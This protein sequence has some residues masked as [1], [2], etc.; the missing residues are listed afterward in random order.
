MSDNANLFAA[1]E[2][3]WSGADRERVCLET[4][5]GA[6]LTFAALSVMAA[7]YANVLVARGL[8]RGDR[9]SVIAEKSPALIALYLACLRAG[10]AY[11]PLNPTYTPREL[12]FFFEDADSALIV[13]DPAFEATVAEA[14]PRRARLTLD[15]HGGGSLGDAAAHAAPAFETVVSGPRDLAALLYS[16]GTTGTPKGIP[17]TH[18]NL[19]ANAAALA[20][21]WGFS[22]SDVL[23]H[24]LPVYH[25]HGLFITLGPALLSGT[26]LLW[27]ARFEAGAV[28]EALPRATMMAGVPTY[29]TRLL[30]E[31]GLDRERCAGVRVFISGSA[32]LREETFH[33][34]R[35]RTGHTLLERYGMTETGI[36]ASN[37]LD[38]ERVPGA[39]GPALPGVGLRIVD[40]AGAPLPAG[41]IGNVEVRGENV[42]EGYWRTAADRGGAFTADG[43]FRTGDQGRLDE[44]GYLFI[45]GRSKDMVISGGLN[46]YPKEVELALDGFEGIA[47]SA[48]FG[49]PHRDLGEAVVAAVLMEPG[50]A[51][52]EP[53][54]RDSLKGALA[55]YK[56]PKRILGVDELPRNVM[57]K[58]QKNR[59][60]EA[61]AALFEGA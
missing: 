8:S 19:G 27:L 34:F 42:F 48:V 24:A 39:V 32:P 55:G 57:G 16:S 29:Y 20:G 47:E 43:W 21:A 15:P 46:V 17:L 36:N 9:V 10:F 41:E 49:V 6:T 35:E 13:C 40:D 52:D 37:P 4:T 50:A 31:P 44:R 28:L 33:A 61:Y 45:A 7:R 53:A 11:H 23:L 26:R 30:D 18:R 22:R 14:A 1:F 58:V 12:A 25:V 56:V 54:L 51:L 3:A 59:L 38:G 2:T 60:R 5:D